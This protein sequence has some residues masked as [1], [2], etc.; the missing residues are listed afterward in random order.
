M[1]VKIVNGVAKMVKAKPGPKPQYSSDTIT[2]TRYV[3]SHLISQI[4]EYIKKL[5]DAD[6]AKVLAA[7]ESK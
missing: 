3:P 2:I 4:D 1:P 6:K 5:K 7:K